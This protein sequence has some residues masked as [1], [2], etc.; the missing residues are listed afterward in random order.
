MLGN[1][2]KSVTI[3]VLPER[4][5]VP[6]SLDKLFGQNLR[7]SHQLGQ[8]ENEEHGPVGNLLIHEVEAN[9]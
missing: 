1:T 3:M 5:N 2:F 4:K 8:E 9:T 6:K 7:R